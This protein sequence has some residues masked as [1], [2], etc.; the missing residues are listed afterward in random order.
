[1]TSLLEHLGIPSLTLV[2]DECSVPQV[3]AVTTTVPPTNMDV[4]HVILTI[5]HRLQW[6]H[7]VVLYDY[8]FGKYITTTMQ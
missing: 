2:Q 4:A 5:I 6:K 3:G 7:I 8:K 1:M